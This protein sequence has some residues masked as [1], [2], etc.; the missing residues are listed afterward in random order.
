M[1]YFKFILYSV[2]YINVEKLDAKVENLQFLRK[3]RQKKDIIFLSSKPV[4]IMSAMNL[5]YLVIPI[6]PFEKSN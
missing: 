6:L 1:I 5:G 2:F 4:S 3:Y